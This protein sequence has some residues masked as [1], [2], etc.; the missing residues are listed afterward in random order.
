MT[1]QELSDK[2]A[3]IVL[4]LGDDLGE[5]SMLI[6]GSTLLSLVIAYRNRGNNKHVN[7]FMC[8]LRDLVVKYALED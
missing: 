5:K 6:L 2:L 7:E 1:E 3:S 4:A 8:E